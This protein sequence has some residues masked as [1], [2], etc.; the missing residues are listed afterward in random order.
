[1]G[2]KKEL[3]QKIKILRKKNHLTQEQLAEMIDIS[4]RALSGIEGGEYYAK[5]ETLDK[6][7]DVLGTTSEELFSNEHLSDNKL[8]YEYI[9]NK[10]NLFK[11]NKQKLSILYKI[12]KTLY[13][14]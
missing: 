10:I 8:M 6:I 9:I 11:D 7:I 1:M 5:A 2:I 3:G 4:P 13:L 12:V 14:E